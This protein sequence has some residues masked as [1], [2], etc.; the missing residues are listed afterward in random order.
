MVSERASIG[1]EAHIFDSV[2][3]E[4]CSIASGAFVE[5]SVLLP[6]TVIES[7]EVLRNTIAVPGIRIPL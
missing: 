4:C 3:G 1:P 7:S 6:G 5:R 2:T